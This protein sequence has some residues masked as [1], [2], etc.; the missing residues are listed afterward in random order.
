MEAFV[1]DL[2]NLAQMRK[3]CFAL[4]QEVFSPEEALSFI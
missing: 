2:L 3:G 1:E 4:V